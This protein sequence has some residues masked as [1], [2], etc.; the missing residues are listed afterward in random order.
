M[1]DMWATEDRKFAVLGQQHGDGTQKY[2]FLGVS[3]GAPSV[4]EISKHEAFER[5]CDM[6]MVGMGIS[7]HLTA[8]Q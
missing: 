7:K 8:S 3:Q 6:G 5:A 4:T 2:F 1:L